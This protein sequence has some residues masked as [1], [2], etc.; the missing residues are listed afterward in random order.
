VGLNPNGG[1]RTPKEVATLANVSVE[2]VWRRLEDGTYPA[3]VLAEIKY[4]S[5]STENFDYTYISAEAVRRIRA[6]GRV[7]ISYESRTKE[8]SFDAKKKLVRVLVS[9][10]LTPDLYASVATGDGSMQ[11]PVPRQRH[12]E[13]EILRVLRADGYDP[14]A[15]PSLIPAKAG[16][17]AAAR[18]KLKLTP[19]VFDK[20]WERLSNTKEIQYAK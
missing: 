17:K 10:E 2:E 19:K 9:P 3:V 7:V 16:A 20:A 13:Q 1:Y 4:P 18:R 6:G 8:A 14:L 12:Q 15:L 5:T 11:R